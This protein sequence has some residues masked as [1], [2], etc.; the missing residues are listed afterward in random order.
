MAQF[1]PDPTLFMVANLDK[2]DIPEPP[3]SAPKK[4]S[5]PT[6]VIPS[7]YQDEVPGAKVQASAT[8]KG[9]PPPSALRRPTIEKKK[10]AFQEEGSSSNL[11]ERAE[12]RVSRAPVSNTQPPAPAPAKRI[13][14]VGDDFFFASYDLNPQAANVPKKDRVEKPS[15][16]SASVSSAPEKKKLQEESSG[17][18]GGNTHA[19]EK[20][21]PVGRRIVNAP[22]YSKLSAEDRELLSQARRMER[23][24]YKIPHYDANSDMDEVFF[25]V[26][27]LEE[28]RAVNE[29]VMH[30]TQEYM[31]KVG[32][33]ELILTFVPSLSF[34]IVD[35]K[36]KVQAELVKQRSSIEKEYYRNPTTFIQDNPGRDVFWAIVAV[37]FGQV[38]DNY[39]K[40]QIQQH[41][42][43]TR[44]GNMHGGSMFAFGDNSY[45]ST[46]THSPRSSTPKPAESGFER[47]TRMSTKE[48]SPPGMLSAVSTLLP[49]F[50]GSSSGPSGPS[51]AASAIVGGLSG[52]STIPEE[53]SVPVFTSDVARN[54]TIVVEDKP[55]SQTRPTRTDV[56]P[57]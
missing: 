34:L 2:M 31:R 56:P 29:Y 10:V 44:V 53:T 28:M 48:Q 12:D 25:E 39:R 26:S 55:V 20:A 50:S 6:P 40:H 49:M 33:I 36:D 35:L 30:T 21:A 11:T 52:L 3:K 23:E 32:M 15:S 22:T 42:Q 16:A 1:D 24:G 14:D 13:R 41:R 38:L 45:I 9:P 19:P 18:N 7:Q 27:G 4:P 51:G 5:M 17:Q 37:I 8:S 54:M 57:V 46:S 43:Q 47:P